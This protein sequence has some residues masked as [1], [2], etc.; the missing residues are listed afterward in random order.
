[1]STPTTNKPPRQRRLQPPPAGYIVTSAKGHQILVRRPD[2][3]R[4]RVRPSGP[5]V[6]G[7]RVESGQSYLHIPAA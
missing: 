4:M 3:R 2:G 6:P 5:P 1:M 7:N